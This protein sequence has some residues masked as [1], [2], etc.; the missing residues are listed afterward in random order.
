MRSGVVQS[1]ELSIDL[2]YDFPMLSRPAP[3]D[4]FSQRFFNS[5]RCIAC[6]AAVGESHRLDASTGPRSRPLRQR[7]G[8]HGRAQG[9]GGGTAAGSAGAAVRLA[10]YLPA[11]PAP[12]NW[13]T[14]EFG[15]SSSISS[16]PG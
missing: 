15:P 14:S 4:A 3:L 8:G 12:S 13:W 1:I 10:S 11:A 7:T 6:I 16:N 5:R 9:R 2:R